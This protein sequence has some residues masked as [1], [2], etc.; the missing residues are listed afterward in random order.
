M[1]DER[2]D[3]RLRP[4]VQAHTNAHVE[5]SSL[6]SI[7]RDVAA[8]LK[9]PF[10]GISIINETHRTFVAKVG[11]AE[12]SGARKDVICSH[13]IR[14]PGEI[15]I[16]PDIIKDSR[17]CDLPGIR[18]SGARFYAGVALVDMRGYPFG[19]LC[20]ADYR[21]HSAGINMHI[22]LEFARAAERILARP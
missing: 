15:L 5:K 16:V 8:T 11:F 7:V 21:P 6:Q 2:N 3:D 4:A 17:F 13:V 22:L 1:A 20:V 12:A 9:F 14:T 10:A 18:A 19:V